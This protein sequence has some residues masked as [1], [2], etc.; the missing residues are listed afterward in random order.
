MSSI[1]LVAIIMAVIYLESK[2][3]NM[4]NKVICKRQMN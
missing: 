2:Y 3:N 4:H 1:F